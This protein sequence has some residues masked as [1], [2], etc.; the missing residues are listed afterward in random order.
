MDEMLLR[1]ECCSCFSAEEVLLGG[2]IV[3]A[4]KSASFDCVSHT[5]IH[6]HASFCIPRSETRVE[7]HQHQQPT[8]CHAVHMKLPLGLAQTTPC[9]LSRR[10]QHDRYKQWRARKSKHE[11][12]SN[13]WPHT[14][15][16]FICQTSLVFT[17]DRPSRRAA[18]AVLIAIFGRIE[19]NST[20]R[21]HQP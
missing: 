15:A 7:Q 13:G 3:E 20:K 5:Q 16:S 17:I 6:G 12:C 19:P 21:K 2:I 11:S 8:L 4:L 9:S 14:C 1:K 18:R 10:D